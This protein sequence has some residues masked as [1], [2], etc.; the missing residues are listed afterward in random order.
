MKSYGKGVQPYSRMLDSSRY[1]GY[2]YHDSQKKQEELWG[3]N[4]PSK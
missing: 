2:T 4:A 3:M 1:S